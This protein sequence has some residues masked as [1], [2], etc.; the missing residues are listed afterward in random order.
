MLSPFKL[1]PN[2][3]LNALGINQKIS[4]H[5]R[6][7]IPIHFQESGK[8]IPTGIFEGT[9]LAVDAEHLQIMFQ[10]GRRTIPI[11]NI[12][13]VE[14]AENVSQASQELLDAFKKE[15]QIG[16][17]SRA[18]FQVRYRELFDRLL[19]L[20]PSATLTSVLAATSK[21]KLLALSEG[22]RC[23]CR[24]ELSRLFNSL[25]Q[26]DIAVTE[27]DRA[28][29][30]AYVNYAACSMPEGFTELLF[31]ALQNSPS[32]SS[33]YLPLA[34]FLDSLND[35]AGSLFWQTQYYNQT[36]RDMNPPE[37]STA[38][39]DA[40]FQYLETAVVMDYLP[41]VSKQLEILYE[42]DPAFALESLIYLLLCRNHR[43]IA[44][45]AYGLWAELRS[46]LDMTTPNSLCKSAVTRERFLSFFP[47]LSES[48]FRHDHYSYYYRYQKSV[49]LILARLKDKARESG[50]PGDD[51]AWC[52][53]ALRLCLQ[54]EDSGDSYGIIYDFVP[55][56]GFCR[57]L[58]FD[59][60]SYFLHFDEADVKGNNSESLKKIVMARMCSAI[61][62]EEETPVPIVFQKTLS[63]QRSRW[64]AITKS[65]VS[66]L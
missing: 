62:V 11:S 64:N 41:D 45:I 10:G 32:A 19:L 7:E 3:Y 6:K 23:E 57:V 63:R 15:H 30:A 33:Y 31:F 35:G 48:F 53:K 14:F 46:G 44:G 27:E 12:L 17:R 25:A 5:L 1:N 20:N 47:Y 26:H 28:A 36:I 43:S 51:I 9:L 60:L 38:D 37:M 21:R 52:A 50:I 39:K 66:S 13:A 42:K 8:S 59:F 34:C 24:E 56:R 2:A 61:P 22:E 55:H 65:Y 16:N 54:E 40:W 18:D 29:A 58:G 4:I 49:Q